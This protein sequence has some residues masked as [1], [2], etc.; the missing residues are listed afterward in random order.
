MSTIW[1]ISEHV[2]LNTH[3]TQI[4]RYLFKILHFI[5]LDIELYMHDVYYTMH[6]CINYTME[7]YTMHKN[8]KDEKAV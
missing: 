8:D 6:I 5:N 2:I 4:G 7:D 1:P 3:T